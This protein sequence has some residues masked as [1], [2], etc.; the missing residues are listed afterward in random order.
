MHRISTECT[1]KAHQPCFTSCRVPKAS[2]VRKCPWYLRTRTQVDSGRHNGL[3]EWLRTIVYTNDYVGGKS[4]HTPTKQHKHTRKFVVYKHIHKSVLWSHGK[5]AKKRGIL[6]CWT[7]SSFAEAC[8]RWICQYL[9]LQSSLGCRDCL[10]CPQQRSLVSLLVLG[11]ADLVLNN[12]IQSANKQVSYTNCGNDFTQTQTWTT[13]LWK[14]APNPGTKKYFVYKQSQG[15]YFRATM[16]NSEESL[17]V[18]LDVC[19]STDPNTSF[20]SILKAKQEWKKVH[21]P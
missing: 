8:T 21:T 1:V 10:E 7:K 2:V 16:Y 4:T 15:V 19:S 18:A 3:A 5:V 14:H 13:S 20:N 17:R 12:I 6:S 9:L 11:L